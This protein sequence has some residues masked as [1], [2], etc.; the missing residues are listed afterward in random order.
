MTCL[1]DIV[2]VKQYKRFPLHVREIIDY[3]KTLNLDNLKLEHNSHYKLTWLANG[4]RCGVSFSGSPK[5]PD[6][7]LNIV[8][9]DIK[10][11]LRR[12][13]DAQR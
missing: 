4:K 3:V 5:N 11:E 9:R 6:F 8:K 10:R 7:M 1:S 12:C 13:A 2:K